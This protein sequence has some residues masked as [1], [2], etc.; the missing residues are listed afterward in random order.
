MICPKCGLNDK[1][2]HRP[3]CTRPDCAYYYKEK[4]VT[5][6]NDPPEYVCLQ[7]S[8]GRHTIPGPVLWDVILVREKSVEIVETGHPRWKM[9][10]RASE[11]AE[12]HGTVYHDHT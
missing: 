11:I 1:F 3:R 5:K 4:P 10:S 12:Q 2:H 8:V 6:T 7:R 9:A